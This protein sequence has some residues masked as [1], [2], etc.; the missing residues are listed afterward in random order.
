MRS[1]TCRVV[2]LTVNK[3]GIKTWRWGEYLT[4]VQTWVE[5]RKTPIYKIYS[6]PY[7]YDLGELKWNSRWRKYCFY[8]I[9]DTVWDVKC[10][11]DLCDFID[12]LMEARKKGGC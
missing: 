1:K 2:N 6:V 4:I 5:K 11:D 7:N 8:P 12:N 9:S 3:D 10:L